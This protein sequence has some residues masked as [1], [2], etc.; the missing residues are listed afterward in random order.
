MRRLT[1]GSRPVIPHGSPA[2]A[3]LEHEVLML[4]GHRG[5][6]TAHGWKPG[7][8]PFGI[9]WL[10]PYLDALDIGVKQTALPDV[11]GALMPT[12][13]PGG[14]PHGLWG[15][16]AEVSA[17]GVQ[18]RRLGL[19]G[20]VRI[21][22]I[23]R[24]QWWRAAAAY[25]ETRCDS[26]EM[27]LLWRTHPHR[28][29]PEE[30]SFAH[31]YGAGYTTDAR[32]REVPPLTSALLR[33]HMIFRHPSIAAVDLWRNWE[34]IE[35]EWADGPDHTTV[36]EALLDA[37]L[38]AS[39]AVSARCR[40]ASGDDCFAIELTM[41]AA[42]NAVLRLRRCRYGWAEVREQFSDEARA[43]R[44]AALRRYTGCGPEFLVTATAPR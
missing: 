20:V 4:L 29:H 36:I 40:C 24:A 33:R 16:R 44:Y 5:E 39:G 32:F 11:L 10:T 8:D 2:Q 28:M 27:Q 7:D 19:P 37:E 35:L 41:Q 42:P 12:Y 25:L 43:K 3:N 26:H 18:L 9:S 22:G 31:K 23:R 34:R 13:R 38:G 6:T 14:E 21:P 1:D 30:E 15:L 17:D